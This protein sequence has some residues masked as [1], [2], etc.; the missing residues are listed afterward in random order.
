MPLEGDLRAVWN[1]GNPSIRGSE[2]TW[3][4]RSHRDSPRMTV[5][6][7]AHVARR[8]QTEGV[9]ADVAAIRSDDGQTGNGQQRQ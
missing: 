4:R 5:D 8:R 9:E 6:T 3:T 2:V 1:D 7:N